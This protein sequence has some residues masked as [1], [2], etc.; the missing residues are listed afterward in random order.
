MDKATTTSI[1]VRPATQNPWTFPG[2]GEDGEKE[3]L[4]T[5]GSD[6]ARMLAGFRLAWQAMRPVDILA[7]GWI[8]RPLRNIIT[9]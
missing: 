4:P 3:A 7:L 2:A 9:F 1:S 6:G 8:A 5:L